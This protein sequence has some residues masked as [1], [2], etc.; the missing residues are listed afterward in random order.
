M[1]E[2]HR[3]EDLNDKIS[4]SEVDKYKAAIVEN[5]NKMDEVMRLIQDIRAFRYK[6]L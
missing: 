2:G 1:Q 6:G 4:G 3:E 5:T